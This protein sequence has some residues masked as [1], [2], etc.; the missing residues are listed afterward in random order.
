MTDFHKNEYHEYVGPLDKRSSD[1]PISI[2]L[3]ENQGYDVMQIDRGSNIR[4]THD[5][6]IWLQRFLTAWRQGLL[7]GE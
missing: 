4:I 7:D 1:Y 3:F 5:Q 6:A 2:R